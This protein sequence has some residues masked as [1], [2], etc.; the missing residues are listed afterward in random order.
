MFL[1][2][3]F[4][5]LSTL[6]AP[7]NP[8]YAETVTIENKSWR[9]GGLQQMG[10]ARTAADE[11][12]INLESV[13][14]LQVRSILPWAIIAETV[15]IEG[16]EKT[17][18]EVLKNFNGS[19]LGQ[20]SQ[21]IKSLYDTPPTN[22]NEYLAYT[23]NKSGLVPKTYAQGV[24]YTRLMPIFPLWKV[25]RDISYVL[26]T[27]IMLMIGLTIMFR[28]KVN[29]QTV[30]N[31]ENT[32]PKVV[33]TI[34]L[35]T[36]SYPIASLTIDLM[37][38]MIASAIRIM[39]SVIPAGSM[40]ALDPNVNQAVNDYTSGG[41]WTLAGKIMAPTKEF[42]SMSGPGGASGAAGLATVGISALVPAFGV[43]VVPILVALT[44]VVGGGVAG[45]IQGGGLGAGLMTAFSPI[46]VII[47]IIVLLFSIF[48]I[49][50][51]L[52]NSYIQI[53]INVIFGPLLLLF[54]A[55]PGKNTFTNWWKG[56]FGNMLAFVVTAVM[57]YLAWALAALIETK[58]FWTAPFITQGVG[59]PQ[60]TVGLIS[61][62]MVLL[63]PQ[64]IQKAKDAFGA[65][66]FVS[67]GPSMIFGPLT[68]GINQSVAT[69]GQFQHASPAFE[70]MKGFITGKKA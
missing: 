1:L 26:L 7:L 61:L 23:F 25:F 53:I 34:I 60:M 42:A 57:L 9:R 63:I 5:V 43:T 45:G 27:L 8:S 32:I 40:S 22:T 4:L 50:F 54:N 13:S 68:S 51:L 12:K 52:L 19:V 66:P 18:G 47:V 29:P 48:K 56:I 49:F 28:G 67:V 2:L 33:V 21:L 36:F 41:F 62:G 20:S 11:G 16:N 39:G 70:K 64:M 37:Y 44:G 65:K 58:D 3:S 55:V 17:Q 6:L 30:A 46:L 59:V 69:V 35:I 15:G 10:E 14:E 31:V 24:T 38:V